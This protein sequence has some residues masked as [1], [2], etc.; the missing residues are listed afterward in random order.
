MADLLIRLVHNA[1]PASGS[2]VKSLAPDYLPGAT[3]T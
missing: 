3:P 2:A 1:N